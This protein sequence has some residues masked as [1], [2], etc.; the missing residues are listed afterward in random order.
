M[1]HV[2]S[3]IKTMSLS[4]GECELIPLQK[5]WLILLCSVT[6]PGTSRQRDERKHRR[7]IKEWVTQAVIQASACTTP[8][9]PLVQAHLKAGE[10]MCTMPSLWVHYT[11]SPGLFGF[12]MAW[13]AKHTYKLVARF[14]V[15]NVRSVLSLAVMAGLI[16]CIFSM[17]LRVFSPPM[18]ED[19]I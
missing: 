4:W 12:L 14:P 19:K 1:C 9:S 5:R 17:F 2:D 6:P 3:M 16:L 15:R 10:W 7:K 11:V 13:V 18:G 8:C